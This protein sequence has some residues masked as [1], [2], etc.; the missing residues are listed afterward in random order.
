MGKNIKKEL[1]ELY[2]LK[3]LS[4]QKIANEFNV[5]YKKIRNTLLKEGIPLRKRNTKGLRIHSEKTKKILSLQKQGKKNPNYGKT[6]SKE[7][8][9]KMIETKRRRGTLYHSEETKRKM[10]RIRKEK[11]LS[12]GR[13]NPMKNPKNVRKWIK[14]N[15]IKPNKK[16]IELFEI[17]TTFLPNEYGINVKGNILILDGKIPDFVHINGKKKII[18]H[19][20]DYWHRNDDPNLRKNLFKSYGYE[21]LIIWESELKNKTKLKNRIEV[22]NDL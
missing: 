11:G 10:S 5:G 17:L 16:E 19:F 12:K 6:P 7:S 15:N 14:S 3:M 21:T 1:E 8:T 18:E 22:F 20:G 4:I 2:L 13:K 9:K